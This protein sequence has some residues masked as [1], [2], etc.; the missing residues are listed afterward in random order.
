MAMTRITWRGR[1][2]G[3]GWA[4][5]AVVIAVFPLVGYSQNANMRGADP[6]NTYTRGQSV[7]PVFGGWI[8]KDDGTFD[9]VFSYL[10]RNWLEELQIPIGPDNNVAGSYGPDAGQPT[11]FYPRNNRWQFRVNVPA[12]FGDK[13]VVWTLTSNGETLH[14]YATLKPAYVISEFA[15]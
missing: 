15:I 6:I 11:Y 12:D 3:L 4:A 8:A 5:V 10:N 14:A 1:G 9:L 13:E 2:R 7:V